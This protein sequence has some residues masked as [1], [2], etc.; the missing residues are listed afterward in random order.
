M[1]QGSLTARHLPVRWIG[2]LLLIAILPGGA[3]A[4]QAQ[5]PPKV[6]VPAM[7]VV[8]GEDPGA[9]KVL[10]ELLLDALL[11]RH[12]IRAIGP[13]DLKELLTVDQQKMLMGCSGSACMAPI[14]GAL[15]A[16]L[17]IAGQIGKLGHLHILTLKLFDVKSAKVVSRAALKLKK[18]DDAADAIGP[19][20]DRLLGRRVKAPAAIPAYAA[21]KPAPAVT[22]LDPRVYCQKMRAYIDRTG[23]APYDAGFVKTRK[24]LLEDLLRTKL[25]ADFN[26]KSSCMWD[27]LP[28]IEQ[29]LIQRILRAHSEK[30]A[31][32]RRRRVAEL[33]ELERNIKR[34]KEAWTT[35]L[36]EE[37]NGTGRRPTELPFTVGPG[38]L[39]GRGDPT[40][41]KPFVRDWNAA[42]H[43]LRLALAQVKKGHEK[44]FERYFTK[45]AKGGD[46]TSPKYVFQS[47]QSKM[48]TYTVD[49]C[50]LYIFPGQE[51]ERRAK[52]LARRG[53]VRVCVRY[54][55]K[56]WV[57]TDDLFVRKEHGHWRIDHW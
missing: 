17:M 20:V 11:S 53:L 19:M 56:S 51:I 35:G 16:D 40:L 50:P 7:S 31:L 45:K 38:V 14:A 26:E 8:G 15:D 29:P 47:Y 46:R 1:P 10:T 49:P 25:K 54:M 9:G 5:K 33:I 48:K 23:H 41:W 24:A 2:T 52:E 32:D 43:M 44:G 57:D 4:S 30:Q 18:I 22:V 12:G 36:E 6:V 55:S 37:K 21:A 34:L 3:G 28:R 13:E 27:E 39:S 42:G